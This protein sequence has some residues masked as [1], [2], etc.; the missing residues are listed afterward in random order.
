MRIQRT[1]EVV[2]KD[3]RMLE[4]AQEPGPQTQVEATKLR[5]FQTIAIET[6]AIETKPADDIDDED[7]GRIKR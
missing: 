4:I 2:K 1:S 3:G 7:G 5:L 6:I